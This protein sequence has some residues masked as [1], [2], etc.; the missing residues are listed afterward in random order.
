VGLKY[1]V[2]VSCT[3]IS[4]H[5]LSSFNRRSRVPPIYQPTIRMNVGGDR[6]RSTR[7]RTLT[8]S[9]VQLH[10][11]GTCIQQLNFRALHSNET[12]V[13]CA[14][15]APKGIN[16]LALI[17]HF[18]YN[19]TPGIAPEPDVGPCT[20]GATG[21][22]RQV[23]SAHLNRFITSTR[24][25]QVQRAKVVRPTLLPRSQPRYRRRMTCGMQPIQPWLKAHAL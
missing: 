21:T 23:A 25:R 17:C 11:A 1:R 4:T 5:N 6:Q 3:T 14:F 10:V 16:H 7:F 20:E 22:S 12:F 18:F 9:L 19:V 13:A 2:L 8:C 24:P 15:L